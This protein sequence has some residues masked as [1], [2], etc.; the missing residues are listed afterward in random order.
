MSEVF[1]VQLTAVATLTLAIFALTTAI[2]AFM[3]WR[4]Q[5]REV[6]DQAKMLSVQAEQLVEAR[7]VNAEQIRVLGLQAEELGRAAA[8]R[9]RE[10]QE[11]RRAQAVQ[12]YVWW[13]MR[14]DSSA[15]GVPVTAHV[16]N[17]SQQPVF[18]VSLNVPPGAAKMHLEPLLPGQEHS[19]PFTYV[20]TGRASLKSVADFRDRAG[21]GWRAWSDGRLE[22]VPKHA[23][24]TGTNI[25]GSGASVTGQDSDVGELGEQI[26]LTR[27]GAGL[28][29]Q[30]EWAL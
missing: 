25:P 11:I 8:D 18:G 22:E 14:E 1:A 26:P 21:V 2:L 12:V 23:E 9:E 6:I 5:S 3:A 15:D 30:K 13:T 19:A 20:S 4:K 17:T 24:P 7:K 29:D 28:H 16:R 10:T 27:A